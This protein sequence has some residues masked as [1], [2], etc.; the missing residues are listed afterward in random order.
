MTESR[1]DAPLPAP[2]PL[3]QQL[4]DILEEVLSKE[5]QELEPRPLLQRVGRDERERRRVVIT[6]MGAVTPLGLTVDDFWKGLV[7]GRSGIGPM[8]HC[9]PT[10]YP[11]RVAGEINDFDF[12]AYMDF[13]EGKRMARFSQ[14]AVAATRMAIADAE[15]DLGHE[16]LERI[17]VVLGNGNGGF[18]TIDQEMR[19]IVGRGG[20]RINPFFFP[21]VLPNMAASQV[22]IVFGICGHSSTIVTACAAATQAIG[23]ATEMVRHGRLDVVLSG[24]TEAGI[25]EL[26]LAG[27]SVIKAMTARNDPPEKA[28]RPFDALRDGFVPSEGAAIL[29]LESLEHALAREANILAE[30][31]GYGVSADAFNVVAPDPDG[32]GAALAMERAI[33]DAGLTPE[34]IDH[35]NAHATSTPVGDAVETL[36]I[37]RLFGERAYRIPISATKSMIGHTLGAAGALEAVACVQTIREDLIHPTINHECPDPDCDLDY[38]PNEARPARVNTVLSNSFGFGGQNACLIIQRYRDREG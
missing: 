5:E 26:G 4:D 12:R 18:P 14:L 11:T 1:H 37:K 2:A 33:L 8:T 21:M 25:S 16:D 7:A 27:F 35:I 20:H 15:I 24:G 36:A 38:V 34:A 17:G 22:S 9:D 6:G 29:V 28:S 13:K 10:N 31:V 3:Q 23:E 19:T 30:V 32:R